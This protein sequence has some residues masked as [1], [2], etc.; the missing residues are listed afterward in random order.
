MPQVGAALG[1]QGFSAQHPQAAVGVFGNG[2]FIGRLVKA[3]PATAGIKFGLVIKQFLA[4]ANA[5]VAASLPRAFVLAGEGALGGGVAGD[6]KGQR[7]S[8]FFGQQGFP[9]GFGFL[10]FVG[11]GFL[12][13]AGV[14]ELAVE[15]A[16]RSVGS[17]ASTFARGTA[18]K[19]SLS[20]ALSSTSSMA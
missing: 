2:V 11:P 19:S 1:A 18:E 9:F 3:G 8:P 4:A 14:T 20:P 15:F 12:V 17:S 5:L 16:F 7:L 6:L 10:D 13:F